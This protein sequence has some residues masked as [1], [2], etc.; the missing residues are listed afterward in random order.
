MDDTISGIQ[1]IQLGD[2]LQPTDV[3]FGVSFTRRHNGN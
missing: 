3:Q 1:Y 2:K